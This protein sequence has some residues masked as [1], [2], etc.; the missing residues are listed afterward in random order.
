MDS[1]KFQYDY[2]KMDF[3]PCLHASNFKGLP[4]T[5]QHFCNFYVIVFNHLHPVATGRLHGMAPK[6]WPFY[7]FMKSVHI[8]L[9]RDIHISHNG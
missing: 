1:W 8:N 3:V 2:V 6:K 5:P 7:G 9:L 4:F